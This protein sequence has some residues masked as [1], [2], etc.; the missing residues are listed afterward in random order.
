MQ[1]R[2]ERVLGSA[3]LAPEDVEG[4]TTSFQMAIHLRSAYVG[5]EADHRFLHPAR[6][7]LV[8]LED[9]GERGPDL[10][11]A[12][13]LV[14]SVEPQLVGVE[15]QEAP[16]PIRTLLRGLPI[17]PGGLGGTAGEDVEAGWLEALVLVEPGM[18]RL[19]LSEALDQLR[20]L[21][22]RPDGPFRDRIL[23]RAER[24][25]VPL[26]QRAGGGLDQRFRWWWS[27]VGR[28]LG[29]AAPSAPEATGALGAYESP[30]WNLVS[31]QTGRDE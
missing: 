12:A 9:G 18:Q 28:H 27:R 14:E 26:A 15:V 5:G 1:G 16:H 21:H 4:V 31:R 8:L 30:G 23:R 29:S 20:H 6:S 24:V 10:L 13:P 2:L 19:I 7:L 11:A 3:G 22:L 25:L 17:L